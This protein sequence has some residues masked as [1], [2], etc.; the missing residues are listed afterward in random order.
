MDKQSKRL[1]SPFLPVSLPLLLLSP[2]LYPILFFPLH[3]LLSMYP[4]CNLITDDSSS[5]RTHFNQ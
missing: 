4:Q 5:Q 2:S 3:S 1:K